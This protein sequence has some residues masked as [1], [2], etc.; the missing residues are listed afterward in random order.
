MRTSTCSFALS[1]IALLAIVNPAA[2]STFTLTDEVTYSGTSV[3]VAAVN[4]ANGTITP[5]VSFGIS[6][7]YNGAPIA[8]DFPGSLATGTGGPWNFYDD[9][10]FTVG[11]SGST[12]QSALISF[13]T[14][15]AGISDLQGRI[16][17]VSGTFDAAN[18]LG[19][20]ASGTLI[21]NWTGNTAVAGVNTVNLNGTTFGPGTY[22][23]QIRGEVLGS[24]PS[25]GYGGS[26]TFTP[27]PLPGAL[28]L[29]ASALSLGVWL[30]RRRPLDAQ[31]AIN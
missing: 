3:L 11:A 14:Q 1:A 8:A 22:D 24:P 12:I 6:N 20:P 21:D 19:A 16:I 18:N 31:F 25:G 15:F 2:A 28:P 27:V 10:V 30:W 9:Y 7:A 23:L 13:N 4:P 29:L 17:G 5:T 26:V